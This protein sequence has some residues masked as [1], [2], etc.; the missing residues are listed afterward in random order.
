MVCLIPETAR[1]LVVLKN[2]RFVDWIPRMK[3]EESLK[4]EKNECRHHI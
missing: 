1:E 4:K 3:K 2:N